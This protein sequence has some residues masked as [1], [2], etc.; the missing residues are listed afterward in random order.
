MPLVPVEK[1]QACLETLELLGIRKLVVTRAL[2]DYESGDALCHEY[3]ALSRTPRHIVQQVCALFCLLQLVLLRCRE[4]DGVSDETVRTMRYERLEPLLNEVLRETRLAQPIL[5]DD[6]SHRLPEKC[7][8][9]Q[10]T[11]LLKQI[12]ATVSAKARHPL[13]P[14]CAKIVADAIAVMRWARCSRAL[15]SQID[16]LIGVPLKCAAADVPSVPVLLPFMAPAKVS[17]EIARLNALGGQ[18]EP[19]ADFAERLAV[20]RE[21]SASSRPAK[22][23]RKSAASAAKSKVEKALPSAEAATKEKSTKSKKVQL[24]AVSSA[25]PHDDDEDEEASGATTDIEEDEEEDCADTTFLTSG[26]LSLGDDD[27]S[28]GSDS[29]SSDDSDVELPHF[30]SQEF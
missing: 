1:R 25:V 23:R 9:K 27:S 12:T 20:F 17:F 3:V 7:S 10:T 2:R 14:R 22:R 19:P 24:V 28:S 6:V 26:L 15:I 8:P 30:Q 13:L 11:V 21:A 4:T 5:F 16:A 18:Y 29:D